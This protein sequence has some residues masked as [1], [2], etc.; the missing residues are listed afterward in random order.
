[1]IIVYSGFKVYE[2]RSRHIVV[3]IGLVEKGLLPV[4]LA[5]GILASRDRGSIRQNSMLRA[6]LLPKISTN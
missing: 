2:N 5:L 3:I 1:M 6:E 4:R